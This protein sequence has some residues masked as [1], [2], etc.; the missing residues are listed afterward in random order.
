MAR[1]VP[2]PVA[3]QLPELS[4]RAAD[5]TSAALQR[6]LDERQGVLLNFVFTSCTTVCPPMAQVFAATQE[7][8]GARVADV[9]LVSVSID[10]EHDTPRR[11]QAYG[12]RF[13]AGPQWTFLTGTVSA[14]ERVQRAFQVWQPDKMGHGPVTFWKPPGSMTWWRLDGLA[15]SE[16]L[17]R[18]VTDSGSR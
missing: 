11:L 14:V 5:G 1:P 6:V 2:R 13:G 15:T 17:A 9:R 7:R 4:L 16:Q 8:L 18:L 10:P 3:V 12:A